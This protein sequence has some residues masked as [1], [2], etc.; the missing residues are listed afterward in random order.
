MK[1]IESASSL[2]ELAIH[3]PTEVDHNERARILR[4]GLAVV[5]FA[6][7]ERFLKSRFVEVLA[8]VDANMVPFQD[9]PL[10]LQRAGREGVAKALAAQLR[11]RSLSESERELLVLDASRAIASTG[12]SSYELS[13]LFFGGEQSNLTK[14]SINDALGVLNVAGGWGA[15]GTVASAAGLD[16]PSLADSFHSLAKARHEAAHDSTADIGV[17]ALG[18]FGHTA[19]AVA[20]S[21]DALATRACRRLS[22][23]DTAM[24]EAGAVDATQIEFA[25]LVDMADGIRELKLDQPL[26]QFRTTRARRIHE[27]HADAIQCAVSRPGNRGRVIVMLTGAGIPKAWRTTDLP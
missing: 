18:S 16:H 15:L 9:L 19:T 6:A 4:N 7:L 23:G 24:Q 2:R 5:Y 3:P 10:G 26:A 22:V 17:A 11:I 14:A 21:F 12:S 27:T 1:Y 25:F 8:A 20:L 13:A